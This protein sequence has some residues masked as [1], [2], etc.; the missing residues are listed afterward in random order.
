[1]SS[2]KTV[3]RCKLDNSWAMSGSDF[4]KVHQVHDPELPIRLAE[5]VKQAQLAFRWSVDYD[6]GMETLKTPRQWMLEAGIDFPNQSIWEKDGRTR[7]TPI[8]Y[9]TFR[10]ITQTLCMNM[11]SQKIPKTIGKMEAIERVETKIEEWRETMDGLSYSPDGYDPTH[12]QGVLLG[13]E[14]ALEILKEL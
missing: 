6:R 9:E 12:E 13:L 8:N 4:C 11:M 14:Q 10:D 2:Y 7:E 5:K 1:M 3:K